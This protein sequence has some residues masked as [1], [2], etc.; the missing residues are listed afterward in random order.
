MQ[1]FWTVTLKTPVLWHDDVKYRDTDEFCRSIILFVFSF[2]FICIVCIWVML[3]NDLNDCIPFAM[4]EMWRCEQCKCL[5]GGE[6]HIWYDMIYDFWI[7]KNTH[8]HIY[9]AK[10]AS[11]V[12]LSV[13]EGKKDKERKWEEQS[14]CCIVIFP[15]TLDA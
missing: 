15:C 10:F 5:I 3:K 14:L 9:S 7:E 6:V 11:A 4:N 8:T 13:G 12:W 2:L 1:S